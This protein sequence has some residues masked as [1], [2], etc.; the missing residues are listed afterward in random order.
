M[1]NLAGIK[2]S[3][4]KEATPGTAVP[5]VAE[6]KVT[7]LP[8]SHPVPTTQPTGQIDGQLEGPLQT[9]QTD[10]TGALNPVVLAKDRGYEI[11]M[12]LAVGTID[13]PDGIGAIVRI[14][15]KGASLSAKI[16]IDNATNS[17][18]SAVGELGAEVADANFTAGG[19]PGTILFTDASADTPAEVVTLIDGLTDYEAI[20]LGGD[21]ALDLTAN[22]ILDYGPA[23]RQGQD[24]SVFLYFG[25]AVAYAKRLTLIGPTD[26]QNTGTL[27]IDGRDTT[28]RLQAGITILTY[29]LTGTQGGVVTASATIHAFS[30]ADAGADYSGPSANGKNEFKFY[31]GSAFIDGDKF[32]C[33]RSFTLTINSNTVAGHCQGGPGIGENRRAKYTTEVSFDLESNAESEAL[34][35]KAI[36]NEFGGCDLVM[37]GPAITPTLNAM[38]IIHMRGQFTTSAPTANGGVVDRSVTFMPKEDCENYDLPFEVTI[39]TTD[40]NQW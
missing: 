5:R 31:N 2:V 39:V 33:I 32:P 37:L 36:S 38:I 18:A 6:L 19:T 12:G 34:L 4:A 16:T 1:A 9:T 7:A 14:R 21:P 17:V 22:A 13:A 27:Q 23:I 25:A 10:I 30:D 15:Y 24:G 29:T 26:V 40:N 11:I 8:D 20:L 3:V 28:N 35:N